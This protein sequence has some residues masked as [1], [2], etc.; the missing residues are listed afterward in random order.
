MKKFLGITKQNSVGPSNEDM[1]FDVTNTPI[2]KYKNRRKHLTQQKLLDKSQRESDASIPNRSSFK[3]N[4]GSFTD[5]VRK[6]ISSS[7]NSR[8]TS[9]DKINPPSF[10]RP[11]S[12]SSI[13][14][15]GWINEIG[16]TKAEQKNLE[17][18]E[19]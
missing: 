15:N 10:D 3:E 13:Q 4:R 14:G 6:K 7:F 19:N 17:I 18:E 12:I 5:S 8:S 1:D 2:T 11:E 16:F 9:K